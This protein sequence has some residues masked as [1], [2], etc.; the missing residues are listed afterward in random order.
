MHEWHLYLVRAA[1]GTLYTGITTDVYRRLEDHRQGG[2]KGSKYLRSRRPLDLVFRLRVGNRG[3]A[4]KIEAKI[5]RLS[6]PEKENIV[7]EQ[8]GREKLL[9]R[10]AIELGD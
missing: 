8:P 7:T 9:R 5:K 3:L 6:K 4:Q 10:L 1:D 2:A